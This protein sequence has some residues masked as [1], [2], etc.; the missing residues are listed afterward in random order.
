MSTMRPTRFIALTLT[1]SLAL[2]IASIT[3]TPTSS[4]AAPAADTFVI[5]LGTHTFGHLTQ[6]EVI[7]A[8]AAANQVHFVFP[9]GEGVLA[10]GPNN[11]D[12]ARDGSVWLLDNDPE[13]RLGHRLL[14]WQAGRPSR[15][16]RIV[17]L[18]PQPPSIDDFAI[19]PDSTIY[20]TYRAYI[21]QPL[22]PAHTG[23]YGMTLAAL[24][25]TGR[26]RWQAPTIIDT[27]R[28]T[29]R[30]GPDGALYRARGTA[31][32]TPLTT[33]Q[34]QPLPVAE[35]RRRTSPFQPLPGGLQ[36]TSA[37][38]A[39]PGHTWPFAEW[40]FTLNTQTGQAIRVWRVTSKTPLGSMRAT[41]ALIGGDLVVALEVEQQTPTGSRYELLVLR[42]TPA[43]GIRARLT[44]DPNALWGDNLPINLVRVGPDGKLYQLRTAPTYGV[45]A[46]RY[47]LDPKPTPPTT[48]TPGGGTVPPST[49]TPPPATNTPAHTVTTPTIPPVQTRSAWRSL[50]P[51]LA[52]LAAVALAGAAE[53][54]WWR[55]R[56]QR[57]HPAGP[58]RAHPAH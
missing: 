2:L 45:R 32:W 49:V 55:R 53:A 29:L 11:L 33:P 56:R 36:L 25:P 27:S 35:Q 1:A 46:A 4:A 50:L 20:I 7:V 8:K 23:T 12:V 13:S 22:P 58:G 18:P 19:A 57:R 30:F 3:G 52:A 38:V 6:P 26:L 43:G 41:P 21:G 15:P 42:L 44:L 9:A 39:L 51:W 34:G 16:T 31:A 17:P 5:S 54:W 47:A 28:A 37:E 14:V 24:S 48:V 40:R 10:E